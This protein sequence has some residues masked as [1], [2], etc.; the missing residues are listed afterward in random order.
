MVLSKGTIA[1]ACIY[2]FYY[3]FFCLFLFFFYVALLVLHYHSSL[4]DIN[5]V[6]NV[7]EHGVFPL[8]EGPSEN[9]LAYIQ[10]TGFIR[11]TQAERL[12]NYLQEFT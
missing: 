1:M 11:E 2:S 4:R 8:S 3:L 7:S 9:I 12:Q 5:P 10:T 6:R